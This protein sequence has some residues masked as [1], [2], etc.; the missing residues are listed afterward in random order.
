MLTHIDVLD[1]ILILDRAVSACFQKIDHDRDRVRRIWD[2]AV[3][4]LG[5]LV[6]S[7]VNYDWLS[8][9]KGNGSNG[10]EDIR[11]LIPVKS[12]MGVEIVFS[13]LLG[14]SAR[15][16]IDAGRA[17]ICGQNRIQGVSVEQGWDQ[18]D[19]VQ[20]VKRNIWKRIFKS[21]DIPQFID[22]DMTETLNTRIRIQNK[23]NEHLY[24]SVPRQDLR[25]YLRNSDIFEHLRRELPALYIVMMEVEDRATE[26]VMV[27]SEPELE[28]Y[29][30]EFF[31]NKP[32]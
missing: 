25:N 7:A 10:P 32:E 9:K 8:Q 26:N 21:D 23:K 13:G 20:A 19:I 3:S 16:D 24:I 11:L 22:A 17:R 5:Y 14:R 4:V 28:G 27:V 12:E 1:S 18:T 30:L 2:A 6:L 15:L 29:L 31:Q